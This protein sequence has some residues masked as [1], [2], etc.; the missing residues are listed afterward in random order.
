M[1][2]EERQNQPVDPPARASDTHQGNE[3]VHVVT[4]FLL[5][6]D[7]GRDEMFL[8]R[9]SDRVRTYRGYW[10][11]VS[12]YIEPGIVPETQAYTE[13]AEETGLASDDIAR[14]QPGTPLPVEDAAEGLSWIVHPFLVL[15][16]RPERVHTDWE[17][18]ES[19]WITPA[20]LGEYQ[21]VPGLAEAL[22]RVYPA[23]ASSS[24]TEFAGG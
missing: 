24:R 22:A 18:H 5:R 16:A 23:A 12:G 2:Y 17:A 14:F 10:A 20:E 9:R 19:R 1:V 15:V 6:Q 4:C 13:I 21:T 8:V 7:R 11:G 3:P